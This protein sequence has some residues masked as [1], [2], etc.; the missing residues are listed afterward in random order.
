[1]PL[2]QPNQEITTSEPVFTVAAGL[3]PGRYVFQL[4]VVDEAGMR[5]APTQRL[6][7]IQQHNIKPGPVHPPPI[8]QLPQ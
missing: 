5:S 6:V 2:I 3:Q 8:H 4:V 1:M 7:T